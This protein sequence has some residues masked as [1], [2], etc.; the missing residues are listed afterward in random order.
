MQLIFTSTNPASRPMRKGYYRMNFRKLNVIAT[1][2][3][4]AFSSNWAAA[5]E[6]QVPY[7]FAA[8]TPVSAAEVNENFQSLQNQISEILLGN[9]GDHDIDPTQSVLFSRDIMGPDI[10]S[11]AQGDEADE[12]LPTHHV[13]I[14]EN[15][16]ST[17]DDSDSTRLNTAGVAIVLH[18]DGAENDLVDPGEYY[19][20]TI[21]RNDHFLTF[22]RKGK[23]DQT[24]IVGRI[25][26]ESVWDIGAFVQK[27]YD[28]VE[29]FPINEWFG[30]KFNDPEDWFEITPPELDFSGFKSPYIGGGKAPSLTIAP[31][32]APSFSSG[33]LPFLS[34][35]SFTPPSLSGGTLP[36]LS[37]S[38]F[39]A[40]SFDFSAGHLNDDCEGNESAANGQI[41]ID[42]GVFEIDFGFPSLDIDWGDLDNQG[43]GFNF[44]QGRL[45]TLNLGT[46]A[47]NSAIN[48]WL[49]LNSGT[50][51]NFSPG[52]LSNLPSLFH[53][54]VGI[55]P[56]LYLGSLDPVS[57]TND[58]RFDPGSFEAKKSPIEFFD[59]ADG[60]SGNSL[61]QRLREETGPMAGQVFRMLSNPIEAAVATAM[62]AAGGSGV[63]YESGAGDYAE[64]MERIDASE[65]L[66]PGEIVG[67]FAGKISKKTEGADHLMVVSLKP[68]VLGNMP[69]EQDRPRFNKVAF[70][71]QTPAFVRGYA[72]KGDFILPSGR[73][74]GIARAVNPQM[75]TIEDLPLVIGVAWSDSGHHAEVTP[76]NVAVGLRP[77]ESAKV[78]V[79][80]QQELNDVLAQNKKMQQQ[81]T[82]LL[83][84]NTHIQQQLQTTQERIN[85]LEQMEQRVLQLAA[86]L[87][88]QT[89]DA[90]LVAFNK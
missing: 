14:F 31:F 19:S 16:R 65:Q 2:V 49:R 73:G 46:F 48:N 30:I 3:T 8:G 28:L 35:G 4:V 87:A 55:L 80:Q 20:N 61:G 62:I 74:D 45:P 24:K 83:S 22:F 84:Q 36:S 78:Y 1:A 53:F 44:N 81:L 54:D 43:L 9:P 18:S 39:D 51:P 56:S 33:S 66:S 52:S 27:A 26:G 85:S 79:K 40:P 50:L 12:Y 89:S 64:W 71:G 86:V 72:Q 5:Q 7:K 69:E 41:C 42:L 47:S 17:E 6:T 58:I 10:S 11:T 70:M 23:D 21:N 34:L 75:I 88:Q 60:N 13:A 77:A 15:T 37:H 63:S 29:E 57:L 82:D 76:I 38:G 32:T 25:E 67:V 68:I 90:T 59:I